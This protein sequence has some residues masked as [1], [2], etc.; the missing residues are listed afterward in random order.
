LIQT[1]KIPLIGQKTP[2]WVAKPDRVNFAAGS[3]FSRKNFF[4]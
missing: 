2:S 1:G 3:G 4:A